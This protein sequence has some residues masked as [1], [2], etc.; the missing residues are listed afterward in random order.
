MTEI[1]ILI[2]EKKKSDYHTCNCRKESADRYVNL[3]DTGASKSW[4]GYRDYGK[5]TSCTRALTIS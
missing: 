3:R 2:I 4:R 1:D 5:R